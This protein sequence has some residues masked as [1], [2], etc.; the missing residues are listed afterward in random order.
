MTWDPS[1]C[2][3]PQA[4]H[5]D[6]ERVNQR[7]ICI[8]KSQHLS[9]VRKRLF[10]MSSHSRCRLVLRVPSWAMIRSLSRLVL[11]TPEGAKLQ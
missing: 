8:T 11:E 1:T 9:W 10:W 4:W 5:L 2:A 6:A 7:E 3:R